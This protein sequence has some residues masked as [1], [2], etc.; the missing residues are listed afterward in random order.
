MR[1]S[2]AAKSATRNDETSPSVSARCIQAWFRILQLR[3]QAAVEGG[4]KDGAGLGG[5]R[6]LGVDHLVGPF[7]LGPP[8]PVR[9]PARLEGCYESGRRLPAHTTAPMMR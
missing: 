9:R 1:R 4:L 3:K 5:A 6:R 8:L 7:S 2:Q